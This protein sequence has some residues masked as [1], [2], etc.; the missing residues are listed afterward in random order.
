MNLFAD[1]LAASQPGAATPPSA[2]ACFAASVDKSITLC[3]TLLAAAFH[4]PLELAEA[5]PGASPLSAAS[6]VSI[7]TYVLVKQVLM[8]W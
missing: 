6:G 2:A 8:Y 4:A 1:L 7:C 3:S 5:S